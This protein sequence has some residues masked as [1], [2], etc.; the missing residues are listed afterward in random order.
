M[1][2]APAVEAEDEFIE[3]GL[4]VLIRHPAGAGGGDRAASRWANPPGADARAD[5]S[6]GESAEGGCVCAH[7]T[8]ASRQGRNFR[9][10]VADTAPQPRVTSARRSP[11]PRLYT[12]AKARSSRVS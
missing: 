4:Q 5:G 10:R 3:V 11:R 12:R 6:I 9:P 7:R 1:P 8:M 2:G